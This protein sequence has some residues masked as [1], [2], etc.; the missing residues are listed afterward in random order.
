MATRSTRFSQPPAIDDSMR[1]TLNQMKR[2]LT[3]LIDATPSLK[4]SQRRTVTLTGTL[5]GALAARGN[6][7]GSGSNQGLR[8]DGMEIKATLVVARRNGH[9]DHAGQPA[10]R[11]RQGDTITSF[12]ILELGT[13]RELVAGSFGN[14]NGRRDHVL[15]TAAKALAPWVNKQLAEASVAV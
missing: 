2:T 1:I 4:G 10:R 5:T 11:G 9:T 13:D 8:G 12:Q 15:D 7:T 6:Q 3:A 14:G